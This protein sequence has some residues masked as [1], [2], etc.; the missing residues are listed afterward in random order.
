M[1]PSHI[2]RYT[3]PVI[4][5]LAL[6]GCAGSQVAP[7]GGAMIAGHAAHG[8][9]WML[10]EAKH[11]DLIY[12]VGGCGGTC[13][14][15]YPQGKLVGELTG[16]DGGADCS[17]S[18]GNVF[19]SEQTA[20]VEFAHGGTTPIATYDTPETPPLGCSVDPES[21]SLAVVN[22]ED[23]AVFPAGSRN[24]TNYATMLNAQYCGYDNNGNL[25]VDG[26]NGQGVGLSELPKGSSS[27]EKLSFDQTYGDPGQ[28]QWDGEYL[29]YENQGKGRPAISQ[30]TV[31]GSSTKIVGQTVLKGASSLRLS[32]IYEGS[33]VAPYS[34][35]G[36]HATLIGIWKYPKGGVPTKRIKQFG[37]FDR[38]TFDF[39]AVT[40]SVPPSR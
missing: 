30:F 36:P 39:S 4:A 12:A 3:L 18:N 31:S 7:T 13:V 33:V 24:P 40:I 35:S 28:L 8:K 19:I 29:S 37:D 1:N 38:K 9:S 10:P 20:V 16:V 17:D 26:F 2:N 34:V 5:A 15:S 21:G 14:L 32:W 27:F 25:F 22:G 23:I 6:A 11:E